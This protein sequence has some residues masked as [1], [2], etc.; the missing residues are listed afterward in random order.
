MKKVINKRH[1]V[2]KFKP[3]RVKWIDMVESV[4]LAR[5]A[6][7]AGG[8]RAYEVF[9]TTGEEI[10]KLAEI[11][12]QGWISEASLVFVLCANP[13]KSAKRYGKRGR[14]LYCIQDT[15]LFGAY[16]DLLL[17]KRGYGTCWVGA[18]NGG[19]VRKL[20]DIPKHL[21]P[22]SLLVVGKE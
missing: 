12:R 9:A 13:E 14:N 15:T 2:R 11:A 10:E 8:L 16:L 18:F 20:L 17:V 4:E 5:K 19:K 1:S 21:R 3:A 22:I 7:S 6:P